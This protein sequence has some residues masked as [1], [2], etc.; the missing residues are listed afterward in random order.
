LFPCVSLSPSSIHEFGDCGTEA[1]VIVANLRGTN[2]N[3][4][5]FGVELP[6]EPGAGLS[7]V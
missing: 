4:C 6:G 2:G 1:G 5:P 7:D 3:W